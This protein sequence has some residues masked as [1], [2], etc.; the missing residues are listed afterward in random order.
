MT[1]S[2]TLHLL[3]ALITLGLIVAVLRRWKRSTR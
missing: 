3:A 1:I 2:L